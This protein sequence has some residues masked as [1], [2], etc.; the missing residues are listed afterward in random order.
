MTP[1]ARLRLRQ[2]ELRAL[3]EDADEFSRFALGDDY[4][5][6]VRALR[7][8]VWNLQRAACASR[9]QAHRIRPLRR[10]RARSRGVA[11]R[12]S[13]AT[14]SCARSGDSGDDGP[15]EPA[16]AL[17]AARGGAS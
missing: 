3:L 2:Q 15:G 9:T 5:A 7:R 11:R 4:D 14:R 17:L 6:H 1:A 13:A 8:E 10:G 12:R 16:G